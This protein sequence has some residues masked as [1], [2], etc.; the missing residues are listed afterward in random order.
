MTQESNIEQISKN[1]LL[2]ALIKAKCRQLGIP[3]SISSFANA[4]P[5]HKSMISYL[6][7]GHD[8]I[9]EKKLKKL[10]EFLVGIEQS[11]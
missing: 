2:L 6:L 11:T 9:S 3:L 8:I 1:R 10:A 7:K 5:V 4:S